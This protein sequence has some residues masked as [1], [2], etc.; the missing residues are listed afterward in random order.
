[1]H[2]DPE[3]I[4]KYLRDNEGYPTVSDILDPALI[5]V[6]NKMED[7]P[8]AIYDFTECINIIQDA[9][10]LERPEAARVLMDLVTNI[11][12]EGLPVVFASIL[13]YPQQAKFK[14]SL[15]K[16]QI[17]VDAFNKPNMN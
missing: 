10:E 11:E 1:M 7:K 12:R 3:V 6:S 13:R 5:G 8:A 16:A 14:E 15:V 4:K 9:E 17:F 2:T